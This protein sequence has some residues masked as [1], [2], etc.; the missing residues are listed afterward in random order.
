M[1]NTE[2]FTKI[3]MQ[4]EL[5]YYSKSIMDCIME[6]LT[7]EHAPVREA[8]LNFWHYS[9][10]LCGFMLYC[11]IMAQLPSVSNA[12]VISYKL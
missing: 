10:G 5:D 1:N 8:V 3:A 6:K 2:L 4:A 7:A 12:P 11:E 9:C